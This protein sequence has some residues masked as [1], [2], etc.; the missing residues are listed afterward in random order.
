VQTLPTPKEKKLVYAKAQEAS[1]KDTDSA[2]GVLQARFEIVQGPA[3]F[4]GM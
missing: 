3:H 4:C 1:K 2:F